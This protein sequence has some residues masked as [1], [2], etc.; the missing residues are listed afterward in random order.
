M[1][2]PEDYNLPE[3]GAKALLDFVLKR[4]MLYLVKASG[5]PK[6]WTPDPILQSFRFCNVYR[7]LDTV[8][9]WVACNWRPRRF[10]ADTWFAMVI[11]RL[12]NTP[13]TLAQ[14][15]ATGWDAAGFVRTLDKLAAR[16]DKVFS[17]AYIVSTNGRAMPKP[18]Y[19]AELVL[20]PLW[21]KRQYYRP[22][23][24]DTL[25]TFHARLTQAQGMGSFMAAQ[26][27]AD[28]KNH[29]RSHLALATDW[30]T[31]AA[32]GPGSQRGLARIVYE[33]HDRKVP[34][35]QF[36][37]TVNALQRFINPQLLARKGFF[38]VCAQD[39]QNCLCEFD[40]YERVRLGQGKPRQKYAGA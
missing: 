21:E 37:P 35:A 32:P 22:R 1:T 26:V 18:L 29:S 38:K 5:L 31:W 28:V 7:E 27:V 34:P 13:S 23:F 30:Q 2:H 3:K 17:S 20:T 24:E 6:P 10:D 16:G 4:H 9:Q 19:L 12:V 40:K 39:L 36:L 15:P 11:A 25:A 8:T 33:D 14:L